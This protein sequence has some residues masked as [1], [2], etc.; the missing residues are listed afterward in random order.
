V[1]RKKFLR[2]ACPISAPSTLLKYL[3]MHS[4]SS[5]FATEV[6][7]RTH[8]LC[9]ICNMRTLCIHNLPTHFLPSHD[10]GFVDHKLFGLGTYD[11]IYDPCGELFGL[12]EG[13]G[14]QK[15]TFSKMHLFSRHGQ[16][17]IRVMWGLC[18]LTIKYFMGIFS[19][20]CWL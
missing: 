19:N 5:V 4:T 8:I 14:E 18:I 3:S 16:L 1:T 9:I 10:I 20:K 13:R 6:Q 7:S 15:S 17:K 2:C 11:V 12:I